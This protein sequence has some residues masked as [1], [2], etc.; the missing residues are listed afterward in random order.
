VTLPGSRLR[1]MIRAD[2]GAGH[3][4]G[5]IVGS[6]AGTV[7]GSMIA[8]EFLAHAMDRETTVESGSDRDL[9]SEDTDADTG[10]L[11]AG[12]FDDDMG[13]GDFNVDV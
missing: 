7:I 4:V 9:A 11:V 13:D 3:Y 5:C 6:L 8:R 2:G 1:L 12:D 10:E